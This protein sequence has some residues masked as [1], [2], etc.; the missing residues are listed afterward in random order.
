[1]AA[2]PTAEPIA[3]QKKTI[4]KEEV[5]GQLARILKSRA[6]AKAKRSQD[7][8]RYIVSLS[9][10]GEANS[11]KEYSIALDVFGRDS[12]FD[13]RLDPIVRVEAAR[14][15][16][17]MKAYLQNEIDRDPI[18]IDIP[19]GGYAP[20]VFRRCPEPAPWTEEAIPEPAHAVAVLPF[21]SLD[22][23]G[24][25][26]TLCAAM[27]EELIDTFGSIDGVKTPCCTAM[28]HFKERAADVREIV[29]SLHVDALLEGSVRRVD[30]RACIKAR[31]VDG[32]TMYTTNIGTYNEAMDGLAERQAKL[33]RSIVDSFMA[34]WAPK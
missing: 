27:T 25:T 21:V 12:S 18:A 24:P 2:F 6:F 4:T 15:R 26:G 3:D 29:S 1:M 8:L 14:L 9:L 33:C 17:R 32:N 11:L 34:A 13:P 16:W 23:V 19:K 31:L 28:F 22:G 5:L 7:F 10:A 20:V 30:D